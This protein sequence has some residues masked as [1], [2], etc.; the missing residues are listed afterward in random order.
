M[1]CHGEV[2]IVKEVVEAK[3]GN[4][5]HLPCKNTL[6]KCL[7]AGKDFKNKKSKKIKLVF[8]FSIKISFCREVGSG[9]GVVRDEVAS[10]LQG[11]VHGGSLSQVCS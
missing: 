8:I 2:P 1:S 7:W 9:G 4:N 3:F 11:G 6:H 5:T 10:P